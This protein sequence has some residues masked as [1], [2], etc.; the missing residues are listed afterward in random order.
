VDKLFEDV[1]I[2]ADAGADKVGE[3]LRGDAE[4]VADGQPDAALAQ[5]E[6]ENTTKGRGQLISL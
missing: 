5:I 2:G 4:G 3:A 6:G 1:E